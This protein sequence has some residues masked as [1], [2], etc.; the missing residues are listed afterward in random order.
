MVQL[1]QRLPRRDALPRGDEHACDPSGRRRRQRRDVP[2]ARH[3]DAERAQCLG[4]RLRRDCRG[5]NADLGV[6]F[7]RAGLASVLLAAAVD[8]GDAV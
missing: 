8:A 2:G 7:F 1:D 5:A 3:N 4:E 6:R